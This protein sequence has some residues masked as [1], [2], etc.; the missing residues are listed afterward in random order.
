MTFTTS[1]DSSSNI[2]TLNGVPVSLH[3]HH[4]NCG[5][6]QVIENIPSIDGHD[7]LIS[8]A[9]EEFCNNFKRYLDEQMPDCSEAE[10]LHKASELYR[11][12]GLGRIDLSRLGREGGTASSDS[13]YFVVGWLAKYGR[14]QDPVCYVT[15]GFIAGVLAAVYGTPH[16]AYMVRETGCLVTGSNK[17]TFTVSGRDNGG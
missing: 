8:T 9:A 1:F 10:A 14:R 4:Y 7:I 12:M 13:S 16:D 17:C 11:I 6:L 5:L 15:S 3:C 2:V